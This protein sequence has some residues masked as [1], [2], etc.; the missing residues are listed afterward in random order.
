MSNISKAIFKT[1]SGRDITVTC[2]H[3]LHYEIWKARGSKS[4]GIVLPNHPLLGKKL[5]NDSRE[6]QSNSNEYGNIGVIEEVKKDWYGGWYINIL[7]SYNGSH[8]YYPF[9]NINC[10]NDVVIDSIKNNNEE[11]KLLT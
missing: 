9:I 4:L 7:V 11:L 8:C 3:S 2:D 6:E 10:I 1:K 5:L